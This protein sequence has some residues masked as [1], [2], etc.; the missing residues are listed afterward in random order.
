MLMQGCISGIHTSAGG[1][2]MLHGGINSAF[3]AFLQASVSR[4]YDGKES[5]CSSP[6]RLWRS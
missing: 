4:A 6:S 3:V 5:T 1:G 2:G